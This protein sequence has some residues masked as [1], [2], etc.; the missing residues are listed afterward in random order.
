MGI[1]LFAHR[2]E[3][4]ITIANVTPHD[5]SIAS[6]RVLLSTKDTL[7]G[8]FACSAGRA[9]SG[10]NIGSDLHASGF[11]FAFALK[12]T[13]FGESASLA[14]KLSHVLSPTPLGRTV[15]PINLR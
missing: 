2:P 11:A 1:A 8:G 9:L 7:A 15:L 14:N 12:T 5:F 4:F 13:S 6:S 10:G 3:V